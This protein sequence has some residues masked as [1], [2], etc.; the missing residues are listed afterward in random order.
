MEKLKISRHSLHTQVPA[1]RILSKFCSLLTAQPSGR[2]TSICFFS[3]CSNIRSAAS[4]LLD[5]ICYLFVRE[6]YVVP[7]RTLCDEQQLG[8]VLRRKA[9]ERV[10]VDH[11]LKT[12]DPTRWC[13]SHRCSALWDCGSLQEL[14]I[15]NWNLG[16]VNPSHLIWF[17]LSVPQALLSSFSDFHHCGIGQPARVCFVNENLHIVIPFVFWEGNQQALTRRWYATLLGFQVHHCSVVVQCWN[18][19]FW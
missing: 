4:V 15:V 10:N 11:Q 3:V 7:R 17:D 13:W 5:W 16:S 14:L 12:Q 6:A 2:W 18:V 9:E 19:N 8:Q 1:P